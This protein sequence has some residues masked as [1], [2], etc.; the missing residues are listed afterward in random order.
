MFCHFVTSVTMGHLSQ[1]QKMGKM[2]HNCS[3]WNMGHWDSCPIKIIWKKNWVSKRWSVIL[4]L[5]SQ[6]DICDRVKKLKKKHTHICSVRNMGLWDSFGKKDWISP[7]P[8]MIRMYQIR[9]LVKDLKITYFYL[10]HWDSCPSWRF[11][12]QKNPILDKSTQVGPTICVFSTIP[13][14]NG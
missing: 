13:L 1:C 9:F 12:A 3:V 11:L 5:L 14:P 6:W 8:T 10:G 2:S 7:H 4:W